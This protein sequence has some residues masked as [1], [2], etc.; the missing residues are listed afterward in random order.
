MTITKNLAILICCVGPWI[1]AG[2]AA[3]SWDLQD[4]KRDRAGHE[5]VWP[6]DTRSTSEN[7]NVKVWV[8]MSKTFRQF[9]LN[10][11]SFRNHYRILPHGILMFTNPGDRDKLVITNNWAIELEFAGNKKR[12]DKFFKEFEAP[13]MICKCDCGSVKPGTTP[14]GK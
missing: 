7:D 4:S 8:P 9:S 6:Q 11:Q 3:S 14:M 2:I 1:A 10:E 5:V 13:P 12:R